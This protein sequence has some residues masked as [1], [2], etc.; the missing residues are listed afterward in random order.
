MIE[1]LRILNNDPEVKSILVKH[2]RRNFK[3]RF[4]GRCNNIKAKEKFDLSKSII[5]GLKGT[6]EDKASELIKK[7][8]LINIQF[9]QDLDKAARVSVCGT[10]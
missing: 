6:N 4:I 2:F 10:C 1:A 3:M 5:L 9:I 7:S 8:L